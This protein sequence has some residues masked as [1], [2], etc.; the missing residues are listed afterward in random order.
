MNDADIQW[1][2]PTITQYRRGEIEVMDYRGQTVQSGPWR[3]SLYGD[4]SEELYNHQDDPH[5]WTN[6][7]ANPE[8]RDQHRALIE[9]LKDQ[10]PAGFFR[11]DH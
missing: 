5:E 4:G 1:Y 8:T 11:A 9:G 10:L 6:L 2:Y 7:A 3:Y